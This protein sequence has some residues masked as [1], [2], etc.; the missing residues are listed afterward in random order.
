MKKLLL[1]L[2]VFLTMSSCSSVQ[3]ND[4]RI[5]AHWIK[6]S[7]KAPFSG[8]L[9]STQAYKLLRSKLIE[10]KYQLNMCLQEK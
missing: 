2:S 10:C 6:K 1:S 4:A 7:E 3:I 9:L 8:I 5:Q